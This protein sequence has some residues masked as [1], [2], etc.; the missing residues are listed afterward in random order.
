M[1]EG[2]SPDESLIASHEGSSV[3]STTTTVG[4]AAALTVVEKDGEGPR[5]AKYRPLSNETA[6]SLRSPSSQTPFLGWDDVPEEAS[7]ESLPD[8]FADNHCRASV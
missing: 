3:I 2:V 6:V 4:K 7:L 5:L 8:A 1:S